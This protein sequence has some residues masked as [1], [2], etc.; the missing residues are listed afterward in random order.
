MRRS[1][2]FFLAGALLALAALATRAAAQEPSPTGG[3]VKAV[4]ELSQRFYYVGQPFFIRVSIGNDGEKKVTNPVK[5]PLFQGFRVRPSG[6]E[7]ISPSGSPGVQEPT[8]PEKLSSKSFYGSIV[9]LT[10]L[11]PELLQ[12]GQYEVHWSADGVSSDTI[13]V[14]MIPSYDP[15]KEY[16]ARMETDEGM[17]VM[18]FFNETAPLAVKNFVDLANAGFYDGLTFH[19]VR[20]DMYIIGGDPLGNGVGGAGYSYPAETSA[21][22]AVTG[23]VLMKPMSPSPPSNSSQFLILLRPEPTW[24]GQFTVLGQVVEGLDIVKRISKL[25][26]SERTSRPHYKPLKDITIRKITIAEAKAASPQP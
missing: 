4:L 3:G 9:D 11:Y 12:V 23:T 5:T 21:L 20:S 13:V 19:E 1:F 15:T 26:N 24:T 25:P 2:L 18:E 7:L 6:G 16:R 8:R 17:V 10:L 22:P 14:R